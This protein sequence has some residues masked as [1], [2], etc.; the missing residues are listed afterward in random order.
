MI[1]NKVK[2]KERAVLNKAAILDGLPSEKNIYNK[3]TGILQAKQ[4]P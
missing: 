3:K 4:W 2:K 1:W